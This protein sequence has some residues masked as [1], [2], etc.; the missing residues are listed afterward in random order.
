MKRKQQRRPTRIAAEEEESKPSE[1]A[2]TER[3]LQKVFQ[4]ESDL[5]IIISYYDLPIYKAL[6]SI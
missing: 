3:L 5:L 1:R 4:E 6:K 2:P